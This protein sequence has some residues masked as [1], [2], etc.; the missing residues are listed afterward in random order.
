MTSPDVDLFEAELAEAA[1]AITV[2]EGEARRARI[3]AR[4]HRRQTRRAKS[5]AHLAEIWP[6]QLEEGTSY[7]CISGGDVDA[8]S[9]LALILR[10]HRLDYLLFSTWCM[11]MLDVEQ[12]ETW[13]AEERIHRVD[14][15]CGEIF[16]N[17][18]PDEH[19]TLCDVVRPYGG[20]V[21]IFRN[22]AKIFA[23]FG[24][25]IAFA[26]ESSANINTNPRTE[27]SAVHI[28]RDLAEFYKGYYDGIRSYIRDFDEWQPW[29]NA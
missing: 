9:Y 11:A 13:L 21:A 10:D 14:A 17:Q 19:A 5:E 24:P 25:D 26:I 1:E 29:L 28:D 23:G 27:Q 7:H 16:P 18:Y 12:I 8:L 4:R 22:H 20:R 3:A 15:Y 2:Q 6:P